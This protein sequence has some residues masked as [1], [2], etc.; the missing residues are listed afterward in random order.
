M[1]NTATD[2]ETLRSVLASIQYQI[3]TI[4]C[5][6]KEN[7]ENNQTDYSMKERTLEEI[8]NLDPEQLTN[9]DW[10]EVLLELNKS[11]LICN[12]KLEEM[13]LRLNTMSSIE[14]EITFISVMGNQVTRK[15]FNDFLE[16]S[17]CQSLLGLWGA[18]EELRLAERD[19]W[20]QLATQ[21][22]YTYV[23]RPVAALQL[24]KS[25]LRRIESFLVGDSGP[26]VFFDIQEEA[27]T[28]LENEHYTGFS[29]SEFFSNMILECKEMDFKESI[30][31]PSVLE[32][33][34]KPQAIDQVDNSSLAKSRLELVEEQIINKI[35]AQKALKTSLKSD[36]KVLQN[37][38]DEILSLEAEK[39]E[40]LLHLDQT[41]SW[42]ANLGLWQCR[43]HQ[44]SAVLNKDIYLANL[45]VYVPQEHIHMNNDT[46]VRGPHSWLVNRSLLDFHMLQKRLQP[47][48]SWVRQLDLPP[49]SKP[50]FGKLSD[51]AHI[52]K[53]KIQL[54]RFMDAILSDDFVSGSE[55]VYAFLSPSP[56]HLKIVPE[57]EKKNK[58]NKLTQMFKSSDLKLKDGNEEDSILLEEFQDK[59]PDV[60][61][62]LAEPFYSLI[63]EIF[64]LRGVFK[65]LRKTLVTFVQ[66][67]FGRTI[68][69]QLS[70]TA[71]WLVGEVMV[72]YYLYMLKNSIWKNGKL[73]PA[74]ENKTEEQKMMT[75][76][77]AKDLFLANVPEIMTKV[78][79]VQ[80]ARQGTEKVFDT[81]QDQML[82]KHL[83]YTLLEAFIK[84]FI[85]E[86]N[87]TRVALQL[88]QF[89]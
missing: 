6:I 11:K 26:D 59:A 27:L 57:Q 54:Q 14:P 52:D 4:Q 5:F 13:M 53:A 89:S 69:R 46:P 17:G 71:N 23:N 30:I 24:D 25:V 75:Q 44:L 64:D 68:S 1:A 87:K 29:Q 10:I 40:I 42:T 70:D 19:L 60:K 21:I 20:H 12:L 85:P 22:F 77:E 48:F 66:I 33:I 86:L 39:S 49:T 43:L 37:I 16:I 34:P 80:T 78:V 32:I 41:E 88:K 2:F 38:A 67:T 47:Y 8:F 79:G 9:S 61:D 56:D 51:K 76:V 36:S 55:L 82:N 62:T 84:E 63:S 15:Y 31:R 45:V 35:Q 7:E 74:P 50:I 58:F 65:W 73:K 28:I 18:V 81:L 83:L 3:D 72:V